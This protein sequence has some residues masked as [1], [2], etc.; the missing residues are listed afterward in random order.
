MNQDSL[1]GYKPRRR[2]RNSVG[3][4]FGAVA[5]ASVLAVSGA[6]LASAEPSAT[7]STTE[8]AVEPPSASGAPTTSVAPTTTP[9][10]QTGTPTP[11][12]RAAAALVNAIRSNATG[13]CLDYSSFGTRGF[14]C[15]GTPFQMWNVTQQDFAQ[16]ELQNLPTGRCLDHSIAYGLRTI[17]CNNGM[18]QKWNI[19]DKGGLEIMNRGTNQCLDDS[20]YGVRVVPCNNLVFQRWGLIPQ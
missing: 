2:Y 15:N 5:L 20:S 11:E 3:R 17:D 4:L 8:E 16:F 19:T 1:V 7:P 6:T 14:A 12:A 9:E 10:S 13:A 18:F